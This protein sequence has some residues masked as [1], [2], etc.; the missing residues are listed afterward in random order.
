MC[1]RY[2]ED[3]RR[4]AESDLGA[5]LDGLAVAERR[6]AVMDGL[7]GALFDAAVAFSGLAA[8]GA[9]RLA[10]LAVGGYGRRRL[11]LHS[12]VDV[13]LLADAADGAEVQQL[14]EAFLYPLWDAGLDV[15]HAVRSVEETLS[16]AREDVTTAT[17]LLDQRLVAGDRRLLDDLREGARTE[18]FAT[19]FPW[20]Y[21]ALRELVARRHRRFGATVYLLEPDV[22][23]ARGGLRDVDVLRWLVRARWGYDA[24][25][26]R[27]GALPRG[28]AQA[29][30]EAERALWTIRQWLHRRAGRRHDRLTFEDQEE[31]AV[32]LGYR[33]EG[34][35]LA[36]ERFMGDYYRRA[37]TV[38][39]TLERVFERLRPSRSGRSPA[40]RPLGEGLVR[41]GDQ[42]AFE[43][44]EQLKGRPVL[45]L[46]LVRQAARRGLG[47]HPRARDALARRA[48]DASW[49]ARLRAAEGAAERF[50]EL[51]CWSGEVAFGGGSILGE[52]HE[53]GLLCAMLP[54]FE[55]VTGRTQHDV[56]H[57]YTVDVHSIAAVDYLRALRR[58]EHVAE[59]PFASHLAAERPRPEALFLG[60]LLHDVGKAEGGRGHAERGAK[61]AAAVAERLG[62]RPIDVEHVRWLVREHLR[63]YHWALRR[64]VDDPR[65]IDEVARFVGSAER[66]R[67]LYVLTVADLATTNPAAMTPWKARMM[68]SLL[69]AVVDRLEGEGS[70]IVGGAER[71][72][73]QWLADCQPERREAFARFLASVPDRYVLAG[74]RRSAERHAVCVLDRPAGELRL[75]WHELDDG[76]WELVVAHEDRPGFLSLVAA[77]LAAHRVAVV[78]AQAMTRP[79]D[80][81]PEVFDVFRV[82]R[83]GR[84]GSEVPPRARRGVERDLR[85]LLAGEASPEQVI[86]REQPPR[87]RRPAVRTEVRVAPA[88]DGRWVVDVFARDRRGL[89]HAVCRALHEAGASIELA[90]V[91]TE[92][93]RAVDVFYVRC[94]DGSSDERIVAERLRRHVVDALQEEGRG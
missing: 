58:G 63:L 30:L 87:R 50:L 61:L 77:A 49:C 16:L 57:V 44:E 31:L 67:D 92:G 45:A 37:R 51:L 88:R 75:C 8:G 17:M 54:E 21:D 46:E 6:A 85:R 48:S 20:F 83:D 53:L 66:I 60:V 39:G 55:G 11:G 70:R 82:R 2:L 93:E 76:L 89:L 28:E 71:L 64:D 35:Q 80:G 5:H 47:I 13:L 36:V 23:L 84:E 42:V 81:G 26:V 34:G 22:K 9:G 73:R 25:P 79:G 86:G 90:R 72:R 7:L 1:Q 4:E 38:S 15:G 12:D 68:A 41:L 3:Y 40:R 56:Y 27:L 43:A 19:R 10:L 62:L 18:L 59:L 65:T 74:T 69:R 29:L 33:D 24:D 32:A 91:S 14:A 94:D 52:L 78:E